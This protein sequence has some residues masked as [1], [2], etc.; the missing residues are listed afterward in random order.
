[1]FFGVSPPCLLQSV[2]D[3][4]SGAV[5]DM[6]WYNALH[7]PSFQTAC[8]M[9]LV[10]FVVLGGWAVRD[11]SFQDLVRLVRMDLGVEPTTI[12]F[13][14]SDKYDRNNRGRCLRR[15]PRSDFVEMVHRDRRSRSMDDTHFFGRFADG[16]WVQVARPTNGY[17]VTTRRATSTT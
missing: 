9:T 1:M 4:W 10:A 11:E 14:L 2:K 7:V 16:V 8:A 12:E 5:C 15:R 3:L 6:Q 17:G 13:N